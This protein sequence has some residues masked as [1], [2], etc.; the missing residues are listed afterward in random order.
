MPI[1]VS[2]H[3]LLTGTTVALSTVNADGSIQ[4]TAVWVLLG[5]DG[6]L[7]MSLATNRQKYRNLLRDPHATVFALDPQNSFRFLELR[8]TVT[9]EPDPEHEFV[10]QVLEAYGT[11]FEAMP[12][13]AEEER[14]IV[15]F[16][17]ERVNAQ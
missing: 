17:E 6:V 14:V 8:A 15:T 7:R 16:H 4:T 11:N 3:D 2:H 5:D 12:H 9:I 13:L 10:A 1:P